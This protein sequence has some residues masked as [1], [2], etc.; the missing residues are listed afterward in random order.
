ML[1]LVTRP[2][3]QAAGTARLLERMGHAVLLDPV[4]EVRPLPFTPP[5]VEAVAALAVTS[6]NAVPALARSR[7]DL[8]VFAVGEATAAAARAAG[9]SDVAGG[10]G[11]T[12]R[13]SR[14]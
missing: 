10:G 5:Q 13:A 9:R 8:P 4:L 12:G 3:E 2:H 1:V 7:P 11:V 6:I 14:S